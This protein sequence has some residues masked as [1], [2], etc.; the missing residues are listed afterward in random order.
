MRYMA[1]S[2]ASIRLKNFLLVDNAQLTR[3]LKNFVS[4]AKFKL[5]PDTLMT[6]SEKRLLKKFSALHTLP[7]RFEKSYANI[8]ITEKC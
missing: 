1:V 4:T 2:K 8:L 3:I 6:K 7:K 5:T